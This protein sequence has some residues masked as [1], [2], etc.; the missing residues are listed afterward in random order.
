MKFTAGII[1]NDVKYVCHPDIGQET[2]FL[3]LKVEQQNIYYLK[4]LEWI[5]RK[6]ICTSCLLYNDNVYLRIGRL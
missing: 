5:V 6:K 3:K 1:E 4:K 2:Y